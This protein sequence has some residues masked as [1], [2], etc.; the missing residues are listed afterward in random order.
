[1]NLDLF[2]PPLIDTYLEIFGVE[3]R[4]CFSTWHLK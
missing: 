4:Y 3:R 2:S 1:M